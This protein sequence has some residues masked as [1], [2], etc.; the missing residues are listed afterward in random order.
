MR[1][2]AA[3]IIVRKANILWYLKT[4]FLNLFI[5]IPRLNVANREIMVKIP[6]QI[7]HGILNNIFPLS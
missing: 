5:A 6:N 1:W 4:G 7:A 2:T 3:S